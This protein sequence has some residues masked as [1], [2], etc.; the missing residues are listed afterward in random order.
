MPVVLFKDIVPRW[1]FCSE[2]Y[3]SSEIQVAEVLD[4]AHNKMLIFVVAIVV[5]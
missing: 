5:L 4:M 3:F 1:I 2:T